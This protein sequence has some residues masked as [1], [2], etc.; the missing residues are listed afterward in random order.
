MTRPPAIQIASKRPAAAGCGASTRRAP[1]WVALQHAAE[2][3]QQRLEAGLAALQPGRALVAAL[4]RGVAGLLVHPLQQRAAA[5]AADEQLQRLVQPLAVEV[6]V[7]VVAGT[8]DR[9]RP[10]W[11]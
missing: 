1:V 6:R 3:I 4:R 7:Q 8:G 10:I 2:A 11:P 5:V 9:Q